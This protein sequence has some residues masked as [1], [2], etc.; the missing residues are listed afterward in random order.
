MSTKK[1]S[2][3]KQKTKYEKPARRTEKLTAIAA[4]CDGAPGGGKKADTGSPDF[5]NTEMLNS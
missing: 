5:C 2:K 3:K 1:T 4:L